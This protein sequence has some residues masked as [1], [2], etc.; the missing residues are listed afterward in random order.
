V[1]DFAWG[2][3]ATIGDFC[4]ASCGTCPEDDDCG[5]CEGDN[6]SCAD[7]A[8]VPNG[9]AATDCFGVCDGDAIT[10]CAG[11]CLPGSMIS[12]Q[13]DGYCDDGSWGV[14]FVSCGDFNC[15]NGRIQ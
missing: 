9:S 7:C 14:D 15:D 8:G 10:D 13:G 4:P 12:W 5:V 11:S 2:A 1:F 6:S 3:D